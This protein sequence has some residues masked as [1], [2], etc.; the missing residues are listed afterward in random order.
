MEKKMYDQKILITGGCGAIGSEVINYLKSLYPSKLFINLDLLTYAGKKENIEQPFDNYH[1]VH[2]DIADNELVLN[3]LNIYHPDYIIHLAAETHVDNSF[4]N[5][6]NFTKTNVFGT[7]ML[8]EC[9]KQYLETNP[10]SSNFKVF[11]HMSTD[12]VY[13]SVDN[14]EPAKTE[15]SLFAPSNPYA[16]TKVGAEMICV[17]YQ[18]SFNLPIIIARCNNAI[19]KYQHP[20]KLVPKTITS[21]LN[22]EKIPIHGDGKSQRTFIHAYDI[23]D[24]LDIILQKGTIGRV[25]N[26][27]TFMEYTV[28]E[29]VEK[30]HELMGCDKNTLKDCIEFVQDRPFQDFRYH[31]DT[32]ELRKLGWVEKI[33][34]V[35]SL[36]N[37]IQKYI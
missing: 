7:H 28:L 2:G 12:E 31:I 36:K 33:T 10:A 14:G 29:T 9:L 23:A 18:K 35:Q 6:L 3:L 4:G 15:K 13:G 19:S 26:I 16:A 34:F 8:L 30:I 20:E 37:V 22:G 5:S 27:G 17:S 32:T 21:L 1:F 24:A 11:L 25:Y